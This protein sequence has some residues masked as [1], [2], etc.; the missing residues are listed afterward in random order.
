MFW[1]NGI[2]LE[3]EAP[4][5][6]VKDRA[7]LLGDGFFE[8]TLLKEGKPIWLKE[9]WDR[10]QSVAEWAL[11]PIS[12]RFEEV[13]EA[14]SQLANHL[15]LSNGVVRITVSRGAGGRGLSLPTK[16]F[17]TIVITI[18][19]SP[20]VF[21]TEGISLAVASE[22]RS[23]GGREWSRKALHFLPAVREMELAQQKG[24]QDALWLAANGSV[25]ETTMAN[26]FWIADAVIYTPPANGSILPGITRSKVMEI[27]KAIGVAVKEEGA[28]LSV[29]KR[30]ESIFLTNSVRGM[31]PVSHLDGIRVMGQGK[32]FNELNM[33]NLWN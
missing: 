29:V 7:F 2:F 20:A 27:A 18:S 15:N 25:L 3:D 24:C 8:T 32:I 14:I 5:L 16:G 31:I 23:T 30:A 33:S 21:P 28:D 22:V 19:P 17:S 26:I 13:A 10:L 11:L 9:H 6:T 12:F 1:Q 4:S